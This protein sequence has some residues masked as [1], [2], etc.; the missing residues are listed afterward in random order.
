MVLPFRNPAAIV[1]AVCLTAGAERTWAQNGEPA[2]SAAPNSQSEGQVQQWIQD[3]GSGDFAV[4]QHAASQLLKADESMIP[5]LEQSLAGAKPEQ[6]ERLNDILKTLQRNS[7]TGLVAAF[8]QKPTVAQAA[9]F[10]EWTRYS[11]LC[12]SDPD[13]LKFLARILSA[14]LRLFASARRQPSGLR[15]DLEKRCA[16]L[17]LAARPGPDGQQALR[18]ESVAAVLLLAGNEQLLLRGATSTSVNSLLNSAVLAEAMEGSDARFYRQLAG[19]Y[20]LRPRIAVEEPLEFA[21]LHSLPEGPVLARRVLREAVR[22]HNAVWAIKLLLKDGNREDI[23]LLES[24]FDH[25]GILITARRNL[26]NSL[27][28]TYRASN[29]DLALAAA[30]VMRGEDPRDY[31]FAP[32]EARERPF[33]FA[34]ET[35]GFD[36]EEVRQAARQRYQERF[37]K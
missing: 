9:A 28:Q 23:A 17:L 12:G 6:R 29:G 5:V 32:E 26:Q 4:R 24:L 16:E 13:S 37:G 3:L 7:F 11:Q 20:I 36:S 15:I 34:L 2:S 31:G 27:I 10:P 21:R 30:I 1:L 18:A 8:A 22:G 19:S 35:I 33:R 25:Q 14:E